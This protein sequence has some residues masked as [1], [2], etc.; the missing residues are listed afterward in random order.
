MIYFSAKCC[1][2]S[3]IA[4][5]CVSGETTFLPSSNDCKKCQEDLL[6]SQVFLR[7][8]EINVHKK[9]GVADFEA[10]KTCSKYRQH[11]LSSARAYNKPF[12]V[13]FLFKCLCNFFDNT[14]FSFE[15]H[16]NLNNHGT[17]LVNFCWCNPRRLW[18]AFWPTK[19]PRNY[20]SLWPFAGTTWRLFNWWFCNFTASQYSFRAV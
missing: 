2:D 3:S 4:R 9:T 19:L 11:A 7:F 16:Q 13:C 8:W 17:W 14:R 6:S 10:F 18:S 5:E 1:F 12:W 20:T 15:R